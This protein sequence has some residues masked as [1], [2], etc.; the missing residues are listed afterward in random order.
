[1]RVLAIDFEATDKIPETARIIEVG[2]VLYDTAARVP[3]EVFNSFVRHPDLP[4]GY[5]SPT[6][7]QVEWLNEFGKSLPEVFGQVQH[8]YATGSPECI[9]AHNGLS[10]DKPLAMAELK[11]FNI[12]GHCFE[13]C[14][15]ADTRRHVPFK[16]SVGSKSLTNIAAEHLI[17]NYFP[18][19]ALFDSMTMLKV[20][21]HYVMQDVLANAKIPRITVRALTGYDDRQKAKDAKFIWDGTKWIKEIAEDKLEEETMLADEKG[22]RI[23]KL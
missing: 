17:L 1:M 8:L 10:Y 4:A 22:F 7:I 9:V 3:L 12:V 16:E 14:V 5:V 20:L 19:R 2:A 23:I 11:R 15:W 18:H 21:D 6:G 13:S